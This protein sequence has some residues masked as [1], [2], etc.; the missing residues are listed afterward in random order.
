MRDWT[1]AGLTAGLIVLAAAVL[2]MALFPPASSP[3]GPIRAVD[4]D[5]PTPVVVVLRE[6]GPVIAILA[7]ATVT[8]TVTPGPEV[9]PD[10]TVSTPLPTLAP[11]PYVRP[12]PQTFLTPEGIG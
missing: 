9:A 12:I 6:E 4:V 7:T 2:A 8:P 3:P 5:I 11:T 1:R 10:T